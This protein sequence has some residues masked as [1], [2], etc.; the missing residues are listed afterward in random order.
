MAVFGIGAWWQRLRAGGAEEDRPLSLDDTMLKDK[1]IQEQPLTDRLIQLERARNWLEIRLL[2]A[3]LLLGTACSSIL[4]LSVALATRVAPSVPGGTAT[5]LT[6]TVAGT[7]AAALLT[8]LGAKVGTVLR[9]R[10]GRSSSGG[11]VS[12]AERSGTE[13]PQGRGSGSGAAP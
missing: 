13:P 10:S 9:R 12:D 1:A 5:P 11:E 4:L 6:T 2:S 7:V 8:A 3:R